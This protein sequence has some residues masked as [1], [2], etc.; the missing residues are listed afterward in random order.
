[1][2]LYDPNRSTRICFR[3]PGPP[4]YL[5][6]LYSFPS[7]RNNISINVLRFFNIFFNLNY[8][9]IFLL[10]YNRFIESST[11]SGIRLTLLHHISWQ[12]H[13][14]PPSRIGS[15]HFCSRIN[16][17]L[18]SFTATNLFIDQLRGCLSS[19]SLSSSF[20]GNKNSTSFVVFFFSPLICSFA[21]IEPFLQ[22]CASR[23]KFLA[24]RLNLLV[25]LV[26]FLGILFHKVVQIYSLNHKR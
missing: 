12:F 5:K 1:M 18:L 6:F 15:R 7:Y 20:R 16:H 4:Y 9:D 11:L 24:T 8:L 26:F 13:F 25:G 23:S 21:Q 22:S 17:I 14:K 2:F 10:L 3:G 19:Y